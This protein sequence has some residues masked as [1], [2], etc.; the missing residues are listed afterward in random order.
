MTQITKKIP[1][2]LL[3]GVI[4]VAV[5]FAIGAVTA[6]TVYADEHSHEGWTEWSDPESLPSESGS[7]FLTT[8]VNYDYVWDIGHNRIILCLN[9]KDITFAKNCFIRME[10]KDGFLSIYDCQSKGKITGNAKS[11]IGGVIVGLGTLNMYGGTING[12]ESAGEGGGVTVGSGT[13]NMYGG[14]ISNNHATYKG[15]GVSISSGTFRM[16]GGTITGNTVGSSGAGGGVYCEEDSTIELFGT[17]QIIAN[18]NRTSEINNNIYLEDGAKIVITDELNT[19]KGISES[20]IGV[21]ME[22]PGVFTSGLSGKLPEGKTVED[23]FSSDDSV[24]YV[25]ETA[26]GEARLAERIY[27]ASESIKLSF[28]GVTYSGGKVNLETMK[29]NP[30]N[31]ELKLGT[32]YKIT[33]YKST[34]GIDYGTTPP[35][36]A[37]DYYAVVEGIGNCSGIAVVVFEITP[38]SLTIT[39]NDQTYVYNGEIQGPGDA[40]YEDAEEIAK[41]VTVDGLQGTDAL[42]KVNVD[43]QGGPAVGVYQ[44]VLIP[45]SAAINGGVATDSYS[46]TYVK[47]N[48]TITET[49]PEPT[50]APSVDKAAAKI[51]L[52]AGVKGTSSGGKVK[53]AWGKVAGADGY[54]V[55]AAF[56]GSKFQKVMGVDA[57]TSQVS[58]TQIGGKKIGKKNAKYYIVAYQIVNGNKVQL[59]KSINAHIVDAKNTKYTNPKKIKAKKKYTLKKGKKAKIKAKLVLQKKGK[60]VVKHTAKFRYATSDSSVATVSKKGKIKAVD[61]GNCTVYV[62]AVNGCAKAITVTVK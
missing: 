61:K 26:D 5:A 37:G 27:L 11:E 62:Y 50:P 25:T 47:G 46:I 13:F 18:K 52:D 24:Y 16:S 59:A 39:A 51:A 42:T 22:T 58:I 8:N 49:K 28:D 56:C 57:G 17:P 30:G 15:G 33:D 54:E 45:G 19:P 55:Y 43:G 53:A 38:A 21:T 23:L 9:G 44:N 2:I 41:M 10:E 31:K 7:Y 29:L 60:K 3:T 34:T 35:I 20:Q 32:D 48:L 36:Y 40:A 4:A 6:Q 1:A 12:F 14:T